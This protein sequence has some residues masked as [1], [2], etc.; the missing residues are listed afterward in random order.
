MNPISD[1]TIGNRAV[2]T[3]RP[4]YLIAEI[5]WGH[6][7]QLSTALDLLAAAKEAGAHAVGLHVTD[8][9]N[10]MTEDY[11]CLVGQTLSAKDAE[12]PATIF[13]YLRKADLSRD[14]LRKV[15]AK[16]REIGLDLCVMC[17]DRPSFEWVREFRPEIYAVPAAAFVELD[18]VEAIAR[19]NQPAVLR[20]GGATLGEIEAV[21]NVFRR[22]GN[23]RLVILHGIQL[24][25]TKL[26]DLNLGQLPVLQQMFDCHVGLADH[27]DGACEEAVV[28]PLMSVPL[29][30][31]VIEKHFTDDRANKRGLRGGP[32]GAGIPAL[33]PFGRQRPR[34]PR[35]FQ[36]RRPEPGGIA[37]PA[38]G[39]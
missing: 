21:V 34:G 39:P 22:A 27:I 30:A 31:V 29:G 38:R 15:F 3:G 2:G 18:L 23:S 17:N 33:C 14:E 5:A 16:A 11:R 37:V 6:D 1:L 24:Y 20:V 12:A 10:Y 36:F 7:G 25:P 4:P 28:Y 9:D 35:P 26:E 13:G 19:E 32:W 8:L